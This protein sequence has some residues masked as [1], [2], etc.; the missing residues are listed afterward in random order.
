M[1]G[2]Y[3][4]RQCRAQLSQRIAPLRK[5]QWQPRA[6]FLSLRDQK[7]Q[8]EVDDAEAEVSPQA[9]PRTPRRR[10]PERGQTRHTFE[11]EPS[12][13]R[14][15]PGRY[16]R[17]VT[18]GVERGIDHA[19]LE[20]TDVKERGTT[21]PATSYS[22]DGPAITIE[23]ALR[24]RDIDKAWALFQ[25]HYTSKDCQAFKEP[26]P[27]DL[28][29]L[30]NGK[31]FSD[32]L[33]AVKGAFCKRDV[34]A[35]VTPTLVLFRYEEL[36]L[37]RPEYWDQ[38]AIS[39]LTQEAILAVNTPTEEVKRDLPSILSELLNVWR[40]FF[41]CK[42]TRKVPVDSVSTEWNLPP[43]TSLSEQL[44]AKDFSL[45]LQQFHPGFAANTIL[46]FCAVYLYTL[47]DAFNA[48]ESLRKEGMPFI[49]FLGHLLPSA[50]V[51]TVVKQI[52]RIG[53]F[54]SLPE[55]IRKEIVEEIKAAPG[56]AMA[57]LGT[58]GATAG[59][60][61]PGDP[62]ANLEL[63][64]LKRIARAVRS[65]ESAG[66]LFALWKQ[67][68]KSYTTDHKVSIP[69]RI[70]NAFLSG[71][72]ALL[73]ADRSVDVWNHMIAHGVKPDIQSWVALLDGCTKAKDLDGLNATWSRML[74][75]G[76]EPDDFAWTTRVHGLFSLR[77]INLGLAAL[78]EMGKRWLSAETPAAAS[79]LPNRNRKGAKKPAPFPEVKAVNKCTKPTIGA[80]NGAIT[81]LVQLPTASMRHE[82][83]VV[84]VQ[85]ILA[86]AGHLSIKPDAYTYNSLVKLYLR[87]SN[88]ATAFKI[89]RQM[90]KNGIEGDAATYTMLL[91]TSFDNQSFDGLS[92]TQQTE[93]ILSLFD[94]L[95]SGGLKLNN[96]VYSIAIDRLLKQ[97]SNYN[98]VR[99][100]S[101]YMTARNW[102]PSAQV[103][104]SLITY[105]F[106]Q[107]P[108]AISLVDGL[109]EQCFNS[110][111]VSVDGYLFDRTLEG[112]A[113]HDEVGK[114]MSVL[115]RMS[116]QGRLP[117][118]VALKA[119]VEA[120]V[121]VGDLERARAVVKDV[122]RGEGVAKGGIIGSREGEERFQAMVRD[123]GLG[124]EGENMGQMW[125]GRL[126]RLAEDE[127]IERRPVDEV[128]MGAEVRD[129][130][131][132][133]FV[134]GEQLPERDL[135]VRFEGDPTSEMYSEESGYAEGYRR[136][137]SQ[138]E[139][140]SVPIEDEEDVH[141]F[142]SDEHDDIH[143]RV[144]HP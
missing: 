134:S 97:Y 60:E 117:G 40:L 20:N 52:P 70:Y 91:T 99:A 2:T 12:R 9:Q 16:A 94:S 141:G 140:G 30:E 88:Y 11:A 131:G 18:D 33:N 119:V 41:Q 45:R 112:Y 75:T 24:R 62:A 132:Q 87:A 142:L 66:G 108:P 65:R 115:T 103:Y 77:Q 127:R 116:K 27:S 101:E 22:E 25:R 136:A 86:W 43:L 76:I 93:K 73:Q 143:S 139:P 82:R 37:C 56:R 111:R 126:N 144:Q 129:L 68:E 67:V 13:A 51:D 95:E 120:L 124:I 92:E 29:L 107:S 38:H 17:H 81:A 96:Y 21:D 7:P 28:I 31:I 49:Q 6:T 47:S 85:K 137:A 110:P 8:E 100:I 106:Q 114:M 36:G 61:R 4:C 55:G 80:V 58:S 121:R 128:G 15:P 14:E 118:W 130:Q 64:H 84:Y 32:I 104:S 26:A 39:Y 79:G 135:R 71:Y 133:R 48:F 46:A 105:Y 54:N 113:A 50:Q 102:S 78:D 90:E 10:D 123:Y 89:L 53:L 122:E 109:V 69:T 35:A 57:E 83:R 19:S 1:L 59:A 23:R 72:L 138:Q 5:P 125:D 74:S 44:D 63:F 34:E 3:I 42:G 98:A